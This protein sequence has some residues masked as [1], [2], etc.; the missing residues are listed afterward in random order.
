[1]PTLFVPS[2]EAEQVVGQQAHPDLLRTAEAIAAA[3]PE[4]VPVDTGVAK[5]SYELVVEDLGP[6]VPVR[7]HVGSPFWHWLE[8]G[9]RFNPAYRPVQRGVES[10]GV[11]YRPR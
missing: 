6:D 5:A 9:T 3:I 4:Q 11:R 2:P 1:M 8:Y 10:L 7:V